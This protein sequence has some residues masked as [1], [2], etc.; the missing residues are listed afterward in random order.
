MCTRIGLSG[1]GRTGPCGVAALPSGYGR[2]PKRVGVI[3]AFSF[4]HPQLV[5]NGAGDWSLLVA[6][7]SEGK[8]A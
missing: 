2:G 5:W 1:V 3:G 8:G 7:G 6:G 4:K